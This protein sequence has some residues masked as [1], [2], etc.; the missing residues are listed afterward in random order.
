MLKAAND[1]VGQPSAFDS[2]TKM[3]GIVTK[4]NSSGTEENKKANRVFLTSSLYGL[5]KHQITDGRN[6]SKDF[7]L[8]NI[9][10]RRSSYLE[11]SPASN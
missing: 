4:S 9:K 5:Q 3:S 10:N 2:W 6:F 7:L 1:F 8:G 11:V